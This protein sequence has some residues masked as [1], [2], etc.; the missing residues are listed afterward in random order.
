MTDLG[1]EYGLSVDDCLKN[2]GI[3]SDD[4]TDAGAIVTARQE[5]Q[6]INNLVQALPQ[7]KGLGLQAGMRYWP[8]MHSLKTIARQRFG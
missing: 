4:L 7:V 1:L 8:D 2:T 3:S 6:V 5:L